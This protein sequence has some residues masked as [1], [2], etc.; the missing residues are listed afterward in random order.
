MRVS[1]QGHHIFLRTSALTR[2]LR[3]SAYSR[4]ALP[5]LQHRLTRA[6]F[7]IT[8]IVPSRIAKARSKIMPAIGPSAPKRKRSTDGDD[9][10][11]PRSI[12]PSVGPSSPPDSKRRRSS[13]ASDSD[14][15]DFG[16]AV[17]PIR[18]PAGPARPPNGTKEEGRSLEVEA[19]KAESKVV[20]RIGPTLPPHLMRG[21]DGA[22]NDVA[23]AFATKPLQGPDG[24]VDISGAPRADASD[25]DSDDDYGPMLPGSVS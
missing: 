13:T 4:T 23:A 3:P 8:R 22:K 7:P 12:G 25:S 20:N 6:K 19:S 10:P 5:Q 14:G 17:G 9:S 21:R 11:A 2:H 16:P 15:S 24:D 18:P 1:S